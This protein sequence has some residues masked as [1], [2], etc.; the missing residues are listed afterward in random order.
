MSL[1]GFIFWWSL[2]DSMEMRS[3]LKPMWDHSSH[4][5][6]VTEEVGM[7]PLHSAHPLTDAAQWPR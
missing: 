7:F 5:D 6:G 1:A 2:I 3:L 4:I